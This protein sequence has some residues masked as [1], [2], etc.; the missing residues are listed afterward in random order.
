MDNISQNYQLRLTHHRNLT[1]D[2]LDV[3]KIETDL[4]ER[5]AAL[6]LFI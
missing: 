5:R 2:K 1:V 6:C 4:L 3:N